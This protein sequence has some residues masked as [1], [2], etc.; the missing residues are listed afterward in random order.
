MAFISSVD[1][2]GGVGPEVCDETLLW[3]AALRVAT[4]EEAE[5]A[6]EQTEVYEPAPDISDILERSTVC[7]PYLSLKKSISPRR[8]VT[9][10]RTMVESQAS[11]VVGG[12]G[13]G[14][15]GSVSGFGPG[16]QQSDIIRDCGGAFCFKDLG[17]VQ[18]SQSGINKL[19]GSTYHRETG[20]R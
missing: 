17:Q 18:F 10:S 11:G 19:K 16:G 12:L 2:D 13:S 7:P 6:Q 20:C 8:V 4:P 3:C 5:S 15:A 1:V 14:S 9:A